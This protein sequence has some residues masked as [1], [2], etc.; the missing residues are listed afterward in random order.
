MVE[1]EQV[2]VT[3]ADV[4]KLLDAVES[5]GKGYSICLT[6]LVDDESTYTLTYRGEG[7]EH[8][9]Y[10]DAKAALD[11]LARD[12][13][14]KAAADFIAAHRITST[15]APEA[16]NKV[17]REAVGSIL[18]K[19]VCLTN[20]NIP[21]SMEVPLVTTVGALRRIAALAEIGGAS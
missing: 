5:A 3:Q 9:S 4:E 12:E 11:I 13:K 2:T 17:M 21:D 16:Q 14:E 20:S 10:G 6:R 18:P 1:I 8:G 19:N 7:S 15:E